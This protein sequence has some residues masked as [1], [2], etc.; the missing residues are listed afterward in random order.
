M[1]G[2]SNRGISVFNAT[3]KRS[4]TWK[5]P[6]DSSTGGWKRPLV[7]GPDKRT[8]HYMET[9]AGD[10]TI[11][12]ATAYAQ[13]VESLVRLP[14][15]G[16]GPGPA[17][18]R[19]GTG[20]GGQSHRRPGCRCRRYRLF[21]HGVF[22]RTH[23]GGFSEHDRPGLRKPLRKG[24]DKTGGVGFDLDAARASMLADRVKKGLA[25]V[26]DAF[27]LLAHPVRAGPP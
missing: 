26:A 15:D 3:G 12:H 23:P 19:P 18:N 8:I 7:G 25:E 10:T 22:L 27:H 16:P 5:S 11:G 20:T 13:A 17:G 24:L 2:S 1:P 6:W 4:C 21:A 9:L 14:C